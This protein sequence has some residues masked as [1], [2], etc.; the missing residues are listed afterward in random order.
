MKVRVAAQPQS[1]K[2]VLAQS[3]ATRP[4][5]GVCKVKDRHFEIKSND[6]MMI[7]PDPKA[8]IRKI[9]HL[10]DKKLT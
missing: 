2:K 9:K 7:F 10:S 5:S 4:I 1:K 3:A 6:V 8:E